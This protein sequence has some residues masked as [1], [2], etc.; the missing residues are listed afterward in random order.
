[1]LAGQACGN[2]QQLR[3]TR[4]EFSV[5]VMGQLAVCSARGLPRDLQRAEHARPFGL[6]CVGAGGWV[7]LPF[8]GL[9][10]GGGVGL[11]WDG[12]GHGVRQHGNG[13]SRRPSD[14]RENAVAATG[15]R[16]RRCGGLARCDD[17][18]RDR[19]DHLCAPRVGTIQYV[20]PGASI[21][22]CR[23]GLEGFGGGLAKWLLSLITCEAVF[24][25]C[26]ICIFRRL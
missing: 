16:R 14:T 18:R 25:V 26:T 9:G 5:Q 8:A 4:N 12:D 17:G 2:D 3:R 23:G 10:V 6:C 15:K 1:M 19:L 13:T 20:N 7:V 22:R 24:K 11:H 21:R